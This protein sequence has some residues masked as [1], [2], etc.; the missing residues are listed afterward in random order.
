M[1]ET[2]AEPQGGRRR[3]RL[4]V[5]SVLAVLSLIYGL[6]IWLFPPSLLFMPTITAGGDT[7]SHYTA[8][9]YLR[10][11]LL[12]HGHLVGWMP[13][14]FAGFPLFLFYF[15]LAFL[16]IAALSLLVPF[17][18]AFKLGTA[19]GTFGLPVAAYVALRRIGSAAPA[20]ALGAVLTLCFLFIESN[21][22]WGGNIP[23]TLAGEFAY[24]FSLPI[25]VLFL[26]ELYRSME[27]KRKAWPC[28]VLFAL[29]GF[30]H[31]YTMVMAAGMGLFFLVFD[32]DRW[33]AIQFLVRVYLLGGLLLGFWLLPL[34]VYLPYTSGWPIT[35]QFSSIRE[36][37]PTVLW[38]VVGATIATMGYALT[39]TD[40]SGPDRA[41]VRQVHYLSFPIVLGV[42]LFSLAA[43]VKLV[44]IRFLA[45]SQFFTTLVA[46][47]G[48]GRVCRLLPQRIG[49]LALL[50]LA[51]LTARWAVANQTYTQSW[52][53]ANYN[54]IE[55]A[56]LWPQY[57]DLN[58][59]LRGGPQDPRVMYEHSA[60]HGAAGTIR[61]FEALPLFSGRSTLEGSY[62][63][64]SLSAPFIFYL[65]SELTPTPS[66]PFPQ[67]LC[68][69]F[70]PDQAIP[71]LVLFNVK[72][73]I[74]ISDDVKEALDANPAFQKTLDIRPY[75]L[76]DVVPGDGAYVSPL[77]YQPV[78]ARNA[79]WKR[80]AY[81]WMQR[82]EWLE[83]PLIFPWD[84][85]PMPI[86]AL[87][88]HGLDD[89]PPKAQ[90]SGR[91]RVK[92]TVHEQEI[93]FETDC[94]G[95]PHLVKVSYHP[96]WRVEGADTI[97]LAS[98]AFMVVY[99]TAGSVR[100]RFGT[101]WP[102]YAGWAAT[103]GG[104]V[105]ILAEGLAFATRRRYSQPLLRDMVTS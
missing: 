103:A 6:L 19:A 54:G 43:R 77:P 39:R 67:Y 62:L 42:L 102:D 27:T 70:K 52:I 47:I 12:P 78:V 9:S 40:P 68:S 82:P 46:A 72:Q 86:G 98:P 64:S 101:R 14:N 35:W 76:Y 96:K 15:P 69:P 24:S 97:Y 17:P 53:Y 93:R 85:Q 30:S 7:L 8:A 23:S 58:A 32:R 18:V 75:A 74:A 71:H 66:C 50:A 100:L 104:G 44:D 61:A 91:C 88:F 92:E 34:L 29:V 28:A 20:P 90:L 38:P 25:L 48:L 16:F 63:Q 94:P 60:K 5:V 49:A 51:L 59:A 56:P 83:V 57:R 89:A 55:Q 95:R 33:R 65:Q 3:A 87:P 105:W 11:R 73:F 80:L 22:M 4:E 41:W 21:S 84:R 99:P 1:R 79:D 10:Y 37:L 31:G 2:T 45:I 81:A 26:G 36:P 13:G